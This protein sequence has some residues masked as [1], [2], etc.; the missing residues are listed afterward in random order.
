MGEHTGRLNV[1][2]FALLASLFVPIAN[3]EE[4]L[5]DQRLF[6][7]EDPLWRRG[8]ALPADLLEIMAWPLKQ[9]LFWMERG[10]VPERIEDGVMYPV[11]RLRGGDALP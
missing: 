3:A 9:G 1:V 4:P 5:R 10:D 6:Q 7:D 2:R 11:R 8:L